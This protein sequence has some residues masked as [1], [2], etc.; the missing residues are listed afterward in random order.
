MPEIKNVIGIIAVL[1]VFIGYIPYLRDIIKRKTIPHV[2]SWFLWAITT[3]IIFILQISDNAGL[4]ALVTLTVVI[5]CVVV[6]ILSLIKHKSN[7]DIT[8]IDTLFLIL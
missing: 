3:F 7:M 4:G 6:I 8:K 5:M 2:Y 1:L